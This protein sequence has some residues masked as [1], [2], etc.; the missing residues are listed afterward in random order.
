MGINAPSYH[1]K[2][3]SPPSIF[4]VSPYCLVDLLAEVAKIAE[5][6]KVVAGDFIPVNCRKQVFNDTLYL[7]FSL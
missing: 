5:K 1:R 6:V 3:N 4:R 7:E 2:K